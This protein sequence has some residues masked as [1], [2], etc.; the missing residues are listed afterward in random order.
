VGASSLDVNGRRFATLG[1][2]ITAPANE[3]EGALEPQ[4]LMADQDGVGA[5]P[6]GESSGSEATPALAS[7]SAKGAALVRLHESIARDLQLAASR[8]GK[9]R[10]ADDAWGVLELLW[11]ATN[12]G[13]LSVDLLR[14]T[15]VGRCLG[16]FCKRTCGRCALPDCE[17][18]EV[19]AA[20]K[21]LA[22]SE[23]TNRN[24]QQERGPN[25]IAEL[26]ALP[27]RGGGPPAGSLGRRHRRPASPSSLPRSTSLALSLQTIPELRE[28]TGSSE[29]S[30]SEVEPTT[31]LPRQLDRRR[32]ADTG[33]EEESRSSGAS[34]AAAVEAAAAAI[35]A[36]RDLRSGTTGATGARGGGGGGGGAVSVV[37]SASATCVP[38]S[39]FEQPRAAPPGPVAAP[40]SKSAPALLYGS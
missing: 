14:Y 4:D 36:R 37:S 10:D 34:A 24:T 2:G 5:R 26:H 3:Q 11:R 32:P 30:T 31:P 12:S 16:S 22:W 13:R 38:L 23:I 6:R 29:S 35:A 25:A 28:R 1:E 39:S 17:W 15:H 40:R 20:W 27:S 9:A 18:C 21:G 19:I 8:L 7:P 33:E